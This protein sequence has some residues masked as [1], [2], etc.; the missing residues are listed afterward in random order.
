MFTNKSKAWNDERYS[1][2]ADF[3]PCDLNQF[4]AV[5]EEYLPES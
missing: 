5:K 1:Y 3:A 2:I 4:L